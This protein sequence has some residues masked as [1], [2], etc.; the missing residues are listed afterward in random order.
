[1]IR[2][3]YRLTDAGKALIPVLEKEVGMRLFPMSPFASR[4]RSWR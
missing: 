3:V 1:M 4:V 2:G